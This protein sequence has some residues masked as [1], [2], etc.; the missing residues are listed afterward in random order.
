MEEQN[1]INWKLLFIALL[2]L[3][4]LFLFSDFDFK[5]ESVEQLVIPKKLSLPIDLDLLE[6]QL[7]ETGAIDPEKWSEEYATELNILWAFGLANKN[8][9]LEQG[10]MT[11]YE[12]GRFASTG[13]WTLAKGTPMEHY[14]KH[15]FVKLNDQQQELVEEISKSIYRPC[16]GNST[17]FPDCNH[18]MAMLGLLEILASQGQSETEIYKIALE[19]NSYWFPST[20]QT[21]AKYFAKRGVDW[22]Q[23]DAKMIL[24]SAYSSAEG[25]NQVLA[26]VK[27]ELSGA[28]TG[29]G[30]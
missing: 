21:I 14:N 6:N 3:F 1:K 11:D 25:Y 20:Y 13:G 2:A 15:E 22:D 18:G 9:I 30:I 24:G 26:Q 5:S 17:Y 29:C 27:P 19:A 10:P 28:G 23:V 4:A 16:C 7:I 8:P 12:T